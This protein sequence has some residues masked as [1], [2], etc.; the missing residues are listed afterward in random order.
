MQ[1]EGSN[2]IERYSD[3]VLLPPKSTW[4]PN[5]NVV[6]DLIIEFTKSSQITSIRVTDELSPVYFTVYYRVDKDSD[7]ERYE[8]PNGQPIVSKISD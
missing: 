3:G 1:E 5:T 7:Y 8:L 6:E 4:Q 2:P